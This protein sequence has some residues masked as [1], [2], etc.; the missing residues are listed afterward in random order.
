MC[1]YHIR[2]FNFNWKINKFSFICTI[3]SIIDSQNDFLIDV[4]VE[5]KKTPKIR[6]INFHTLEWYNLILNR[7]MHRNLP[8]RLHKHIFWITYTNLD[9]IKSFFRTLFFP[10]EGPIRA[11]LVWKYDVLPL[12]NACWYAW[13]A[14]GPLAITSAGALPA[15][16]KLYENKGKTECVASF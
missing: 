15:E 9:W 13:I 8:G 6:I 14:S 2:F 1:A 16:N 5:E 7:V 12:V 4:I 10:S 11:I 3:I